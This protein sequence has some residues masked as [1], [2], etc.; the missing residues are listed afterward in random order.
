[1]SE[2]EGTEA[3]R[4][5]A[6]RVVALRRLLPFL[7]PYKLVVAGAAVALVVAAGTVLAIGQAIR[8]V[9]DHG[10]GGDGAFIDLYFIALLGV[11]AVLAGATFARYF[12]V[13]WLGE[14]V[15]ADLRKAVYDHVIGLSPAF[16]EATRTGE[17]LSRLTADTTLIQTVVGSSA[18]VA[19]RNF[20]MFVGGSVLLLITSPKLTGIVF[21]MLPL[22]IAPIVLFGRK[23]RRLSRDS[24]DRVADV[25]GHAEESLNA[26]QVVQAFCHEALDRLR[27]ATVADDAFRVAVRR[28]RAR[29]W[30]TALV[31]LLV[32][33]AVDIV[34]WIGAT[35]V[36]AG[37]M[38]GGELAAFVFYAIVV[39]GALGALSEVYGELQRAAGATERLIELLEVAPVIRAPASPQPLPD[40]AAGAVAFADVTFHY[41]TRPETAALANFDLAIAAG[42]TVA[43]VGPSGAGKSTVFQLLLRFYDPDG[44]TVR[45]D[46]VP[47]DQAD[48]AAI[49]ARLG[50]VPQDAVI[51]A[52]DAMENI[53]YGRPG[54][55]DD[56]VIAAA[57][58]AHARGFIEALP[59]G[60]R[61]FLGERGLRLSGGQRQRIAIARAIL[62]DPAVLLLD[63]ATSALDAESERLVQA[64]MERLMSD[65]TTI[66][67]AHRLATVLKA[68]RIVV[69]DHGRI[70]ETG[71][72]DELLRAG[73]LYAHFAAL[74][75]EAGEAFAE[76]SRR[77]AAGE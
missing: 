21:L 42:E 57:D 56:E 50:L 20:L 9:V 38:S 29:A 65:R 34:V 74:Q 69:M 31:M 7:A 77:L 23:V 18:S 45:L 59:Q 26:L 62:R 8:R 73:G 11:V 52:A 49:R 41:P 43:L 27:F 35:D 47:L 25:S 39:A 58:A 61:T 4:A 2:R 16:F 66:V 17:V 36:A 46:G 68:D 28:T 24:Q 64:A 48:P 13:T 53:R 63:E 67:I 30:L 75:F 72:H 6:K 55:S 37:A 12:L 19:M 14:R 5:P 44:G 3:P 76:A 70:V 40:P 22:V 10:F 51:F 33:G 15:V 1:M 71:T 32:F 54:A 60:F